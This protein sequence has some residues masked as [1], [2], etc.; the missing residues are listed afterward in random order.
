MRS[1]KGERG[2]ISI[3]MIVGILVLLFVL[4]EGK[5]F[6]PLLMRQFQ[7][8]DAVIEASKFSATKDAAAVQNELAYKASELKLPISREMIKVTK[9][10]T[11]TRVQIVYELSAE[12][13]PRK[14]YKWTVTVDEESKIF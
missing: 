5:Q 14:P 10:G 1:M 4:Y 6:G 7:F 9:G 12:W 3:G 13:L 11:Y 2:A 8:Q